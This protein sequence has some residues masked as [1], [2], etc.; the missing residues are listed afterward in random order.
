MISPKVRA[1]QP[2]FLP[3]GNKFFLFFEGVKAY[4][5]F[6]FSNNGNWEKSL[7]VDSAMQ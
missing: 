2:T 3:I 7:G 5:I 6:C 4:F 1:T